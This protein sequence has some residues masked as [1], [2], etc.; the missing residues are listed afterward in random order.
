MDQ[1]PVSQC[2]VDERI[3]IWE[4][5]QNGITIRKVADAAGA[6]GA[7]LNKRSDMFLVAIIDGNLIA[8]GHQVA[9]EI[10]SHM[11]QADDADALNETFRI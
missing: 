9:G 4:R 8:I 3:I 7:P 10:A 11:T 2:H 6:S 5:C 1:S